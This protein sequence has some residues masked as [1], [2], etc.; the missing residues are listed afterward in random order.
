MCVPCPESSSL[1]HPLHSSPSGNNRSSFQ[2]SAKILKELRHSPCNPQASHFPCSL[3]TRTNV[4]LRNYVRVSSGLQRL[5]PSRLQAT[6][7]QGVSLHCSSVQHSTRPGSTVFIEGMS[8]CTK[9][10]TAGC[11]RSREKYKCKW[12]HKEGR[13][14]FLLQGSGGERLCWVWTEQGGLLLSPVP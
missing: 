2:I 5:P 1:L 6:G 12:E 9:E 8:K 13:E 7:E 3:S 10:A 4:H 14:S 11:D